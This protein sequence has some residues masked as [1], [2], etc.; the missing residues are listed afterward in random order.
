M[1]RWRWWRVMMTNPASLVRDLV[2]PSISPP[3]PS[4]YFLCRDR[5][6]P[7]YLRIPGSFGRSV[8]KTDLPSGAL[9]MNTPDGQ[10]RC[11]GV[12]EH[13]F[14]IRI[15]TD[16]P[17]HVGCGGRPP[18]PK[19]RTPTPVSK[20]RSMSFDGRP[21]QLCESRVLASNAKFPFVHEQTAPSGF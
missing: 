8:G 18:A 17:G 11:S 6:R 5:T 3:F 13:I 12:H 7:G 1:R 9:F 2:A 14:L 21:L 10:H 16:R 15:F 19:Q 4:G 20:G